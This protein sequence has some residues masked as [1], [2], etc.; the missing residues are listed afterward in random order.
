MRLTEVNQVQKI[1]E[2]FL[3]LILPKIL[4][5]RNSEDDT[6]KQEPGKGKIQ[7]LELDTKKRKF[8]EGKRE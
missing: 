2:L 4:K 8:G 5:N 3:F 6:N 1:V 7:T